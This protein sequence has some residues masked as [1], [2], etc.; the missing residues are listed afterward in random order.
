MK[1][2][3]LNRQKAKAAGYAEHL[4][5]MGSWVNDD[6]VLEYGIFRSGTMIGAVGCGIESAHEFSMNN[7]INIMFD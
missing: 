1:R 6:R 3:Y 7:F 5:N 2:L 4:R